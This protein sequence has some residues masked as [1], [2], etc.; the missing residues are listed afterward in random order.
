MD[1]E[2]EPEVCAPEKGEGEELIEVFADV[3]GEHYH[4]VDEHWFT[5]VEMDIT[6]CHLDQTNDNS[7]RLQPVQYSERYSDRIDQNKPNI[8]ADSMSMSIERRLA[9]SS[10]TSTSASCNNC[11]RKK[12]KKEK[13]GI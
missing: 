3:L 13:G 1:F 2:I 10:G 11:G 4:G 6:T 12:E 7:S 8:Q 9:S 5:D